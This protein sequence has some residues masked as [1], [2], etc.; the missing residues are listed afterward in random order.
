MKFKP[1]NLRTV[2]V[3]RISD[4][5]A[6][7]VVK[8]GSHDQFQAGCPVSILLH[9]GRYVHGEVAEQWRAEGH[10]E[11]V[12]LQ[13]IVHVLP[14][15]TIAHMVASKRMEAEGTHIAKNVRESS[16]SHCCFNLKDQ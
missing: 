16:V 10:C 9:T 13:D 8:H 7:F 6:D 15:Y 5:G 11:S 14:E 1:P 12:P 4:L 3:Q 2:G